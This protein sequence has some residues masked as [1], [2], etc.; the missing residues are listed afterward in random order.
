MVK[1]TQKIDLVKIMSE[2]YPQ[3]VDKKKIKYPIEDSLFAEIPELT[4]DLALSQR[5][6]AE[7]INISNSHFEDLIQVHT[8][9]GKFK[10]YLKIKE[11]FSLEELY[12][13]LTF[14]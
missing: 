1:P 7:R 5:P 13:A 6:N 4:Q 14:T 8:F 9:F 2:H 12:T 3:F 10:N 11:D